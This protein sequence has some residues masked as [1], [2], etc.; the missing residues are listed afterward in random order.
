ME[1]CGFAISLETCQS[2]N[3]SEFIHVDGVLIEGPD[4]G[5]LGMFFVIGSLY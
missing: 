2:G 3:T 5:A 4:L 1:T